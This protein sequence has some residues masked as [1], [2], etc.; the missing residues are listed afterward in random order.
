VRRV[1]DERGAATAEL[2]IATP[3]LL[4]LLLLVVHVGLWFHAAHVA[5]A[6]AQEGAR[7]ARNEDGTR[8]AG[9]DAANRLLDELGARLVMD[10]DVDVERG[11]DEVRVVVTGHGPTV[12][13]GL[14]LP[15]RAESVGPVEVFRPVE[16]GGG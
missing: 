12:V 2:V 6:A 13:P 8:E 4:F 3:A 15:I 7:A 11:A 5:S 14:R 9:E 1:A 16:A 10:R